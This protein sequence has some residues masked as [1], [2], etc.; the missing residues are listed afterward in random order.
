MYQVPATLLKGPTLV[1]SPLL[2]LIEDQLHM[3][4]PAPGEA[5]RRPSTLYLSVK[6]GTIR[7]GGNVIELGR[8]ALSL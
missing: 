6:G 2:A 1:I 8:G 3:R 4:R 7:V 5:V